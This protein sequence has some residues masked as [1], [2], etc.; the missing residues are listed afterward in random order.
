[1]LFVQKLSRSPLSTANAIIGVLIPAAIRDFD[2]CFYHSHSTYIR[3]HSLPEPLTFPNLEDSVGE[4]RFLF[5]LNESLHVEFLYSAVMV[6]A[7]L[8]GVDVQYLQE[9]INYQKFATM[10]TNTTKTLDMVSGTPSKYNNNYQFFQRIYT[11]SNR[12][13]VCRAGGCT[14]ESQ[15]VSFRLQNLAAVSYEEIVSQKPQTK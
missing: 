9:H 5:D 3:K 2:Y 10:V 11:F 12:T 7:Y 8:F 15:I 13:N 1:V 4:N 14:N 6:T